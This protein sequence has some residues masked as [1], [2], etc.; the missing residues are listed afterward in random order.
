MSG[1]REGG[2]KAAATNKARHGKDW[3]A[4][5]GQKG[6]RNGH[7][8]GFASNTI[9]KDGLTGPERAK[10]WGAVGGAKGKR[11]PSKKNAIPHLAD[12]DIQKAKK[13]KGWVWPFS[14]NAK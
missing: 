2:K 4:K 10:K 8:G 11:G 9:G 13:K 7:T 5:I 3:Y 14:R 12:D 6:G 1:N